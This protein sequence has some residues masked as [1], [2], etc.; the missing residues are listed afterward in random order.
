M[1][2]RSAV[3]QELCMYRQK[4]VRTNGDREM[5]SLSTEMPTRLAQEI[6]ALKK[7]GTHNPGLK[8]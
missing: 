8:K 6:S 2:I 4:T 1:K 5:S 3:L 7:I